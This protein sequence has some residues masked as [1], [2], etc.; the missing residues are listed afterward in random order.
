MPSIT[1]FRTPKYIP[2]LGTVTKSDP[3]LASLTFGAE[4]PSAPHPQEGPSHESYC[5]AI[6]QKQ[7][8]YVCKRCLDFCLA[9]SALILLLPLLLLIALLIKVDSS[10]PIFFTHERVGT[11]RARLRGEAVW[12]IENFPMHKFRSMVQNADSAAHEAY[13][14][15]FVQGRV[16]PD[17]AKG[18]KFKLTNDPRVTRIGR[19][20][21]RTSLDE[22]PQLFN[23]LKGQMSLVGPRPVPPY[24][25]ACYR[26][27]DHKRLTAPPGITGLWQVNGRC[28][29]SF[30]EMIHMDLEYIQKASLW[31]DLRILFLTIP[32]VLCGRGAE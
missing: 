7:L 13:I 30:E 1:S 11:K 18:G 5:T 10:G 3:A 17:R 19:I 22:L 20:L 14:R 25:V 15:D 23:V 12:V 31:I 29:V 28:Q 6:S 32:A 27:G 24:E 4:P 26:P 16:Q 2:G 21:R 8:Y 9:V